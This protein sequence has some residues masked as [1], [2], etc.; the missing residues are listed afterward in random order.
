L[1]LLDGQQ[2]LLLLLPAAQLIQL[3]L[4]SLPKRRGSQLI[5]C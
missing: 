5:H 1:Q 3:T 2:L 4:H